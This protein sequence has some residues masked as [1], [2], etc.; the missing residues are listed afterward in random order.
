M[1]TQVQTTDFTVK[2]GVNDDRNSVIVRGCMPFEI[3]DE[4][5]VIPYTQGTVIHRIDDKNFL[6][7]T[8]SLN[9]HERTVK[10]YNKNGKSVRFPNFRED[11]VLIC[12]FD[13][14]PYTEFTVDDFEIAFVT[15]KYSAVIK[16]DH[17]FK[18]SYY[19]AIL[20]DEKLTRVKK[21]DD[22]FKVMSYSPS[23]VSMYPV[24][25]GGS[26][27]LTVPNYWLGQEVVLIRW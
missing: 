12:K 1:I 24:M 4:V 3:G 2:D 11:K 15:E 26:P 23:I 7:Q 14:M 9:I 8:D 16:V 18:D 25:W 27:V 21:I 17:H 22:K 19:T 5:L 20:Y 10:R 13:E 6:I